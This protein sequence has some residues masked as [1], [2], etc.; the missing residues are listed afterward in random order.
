MSRPAAV[1]GSGSNPRPAQQGVAL[2]VVMMFLIAI[3]GIGL[4]TAR[5]SVLSEGMARNQT[6]QAVAWQAAEAAL[7]DAER[8]FMTAF[9]S[10]A[11]NASCS[12]GKVALNPNDFSTDCKRGLCAIPEAAYATAS[13]VAASGTTAEP[14]WPGGKS[15]LWSDDL[16]KKPGRVPVD[17]NNCD[18]FAGGVPLGTYTGTAA[19]IGVA[20]QPEYMIEYFKR[21]NVRINQ[22]ETQVSGQG[23][24]PNEWSAMYRITARGFGYSERTQ[25][26]LQTIFMP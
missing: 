15:G 10:V 25:V 9:S 5:Q 13:W 18:S 7:R 21:K 11:T 20:R 16:T 2:V 24:N 23:S 1:A 26:V 14:W 4:W 8:D 3:T 17:H 19:L 6:D 12:R 22:V